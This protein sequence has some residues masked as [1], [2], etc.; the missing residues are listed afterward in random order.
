MPGLAEN[1]L[2][3]LLEN[4][5][6]KTLNKI[7]VSELP[8]LLRLLGSSTYLSDALIRQGSNWPELFLRQIKV[9]HKTAAEHRAAAS[10]DHQLPADPDDA[11]GAGDGKPAGQ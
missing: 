7:P 9:Q 10:A 2:L 3:R 5:G 1:H 6:L 4:G 8:A 11:A